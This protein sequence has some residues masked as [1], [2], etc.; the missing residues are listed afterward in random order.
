[1]SETDPYPLRRFDIAPQAI[2]RVVAVFYAR[3]RQH[4]VLGPVFAAHVTD[5][6]AHEARIAGFWRN[7]ILRERSYAGNPLNVHVRHSDV[8]PE[9]FPQWLDLFHAVLAEELPPGPAANWGA[10][11]DRIGAGFRAGVVSMRQP[12]D[13]PPAL[14]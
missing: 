4:P 10:L 2:D 8:L 9:H 12:K 11:A 14:F 13:A 1:M 6:P 5:W 3:I 7:A